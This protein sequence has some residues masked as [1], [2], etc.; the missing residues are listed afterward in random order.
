MQLQLLYSDPTYLCF[1]RAG[2]R[3][4]RSLNK[5]V[6]AG[7]QLSLIAWGS[8]EYS[9]FSTCGRALRFK[10]CWHTNTLLPVVVCT[11]LISMWFG[12]VVS[13]T[14]LMETYQSF[15]KINNMIR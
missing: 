14:L 6:L 4:L 13:L 7:V 10:K 15:T 3:E 12:L 8:L 2:L 5:H 11:I 1:S 9:A